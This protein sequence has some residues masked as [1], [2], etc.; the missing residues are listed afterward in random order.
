MKTSFYTLGENT[1]CLSVTFTGI[2]GGEWEH[3]C[4]MICD[5]ILGE[6]PYSE[7]SAEDLIEVVAMESADGDEYV[8]AVFLQGKLV[9]SIDAPFWYPVNEYVRI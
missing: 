5:H 7:A 1:P 4:E 3:M 8:E 6:D 9:G 2:T